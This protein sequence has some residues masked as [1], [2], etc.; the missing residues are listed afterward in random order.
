M[1][2]ANV[3]VLGAGPAGLIAAHTLLKA[4]CG[5]AVW[6][7]G[8][9]EAGPTKS[10]LHGCQ[11]LHAPVVG[12]PYSYIDVDYRLEGTVEDYRAKVYGEAYQGPTSPDEYG[13]GEPHRAWDLRAAYDALWEFWSHRI[14]CADLDAGYMAAFQA[15]ADLDLIVSTVPA[16]TLCRSVPGLAPGKDE[17]LFESQSVYAI[18]QRVGD[19]RFL[20][21]G[22]E[23]VVECNG[24]KDVGW[25]RK[26][27]VFGYTTVEWPVRRKPPVP[28]VRL[29]QKPIRTTCDCW[30]EDRIPVL[31]V[32]R[33]GVWRKGYLTHHVVEDVHKALNNLQPR[34]F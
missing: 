7:R 13:V 30:L 20:F 6:S 5:V 18:G 2:S 19:G 14:T 26:A 3:L 8:D 11:Y 24:T 29:I 31:R 17:H 12:D 9:E 28:G 15:K 25:Y 32:G 22:T 33:Y 16:L 1:T 34:M 21:T 4:G 23:G 27:T 10:E